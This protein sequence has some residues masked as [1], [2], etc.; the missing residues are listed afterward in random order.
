MYLL[1]PKERES[2]N[3]RVA[4]SLRLDP[5][6]LLANLD[7]GSAPIDPG[8][9]AS[10]LGV[11]V[12]R[13]RDP[14]WSG[15]L[16][17]DGGEP[18]IWVNADEADVRRRFTMAH[19]LGHLLYHPLRAQYRDSDRQYRDRSASVEAEANRFAANLLMP[20]WLVERYIRRG[21]RLDTLAAI[22][23]VSEEAMG[24]QLG[25]GRGRGRTRGDDLDLE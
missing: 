7:I 12:R 2:L 17:V 21:T 11:P 19:E 16:T 8:V 4:R 13:V 3:W 20:P 14:G 22:F 18:T 6:D 10:R 25:W 1:T 9:V 24:I 5:S 23:M 15:A